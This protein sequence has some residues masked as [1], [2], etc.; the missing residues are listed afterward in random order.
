[1]RGLCRG[2]FATA[3]YATVQV[4]SP[5]TTRAAVSR[6]VPQQNSDALFLLPAPV[7]FQT[8]N[9]WSGLVWPGI[10]EIP[11]CWTLSRPGWKKGFS[12]LQHYLPGDW[13]V[14]GK[15]YPAQSPETL[16][17]VFPVA[18]KESRCHIFL[19]LPWVRQGERWRM[20]GALP[21]LKQGRTE[22]P[23]PRPGSRGA[24]SFIK[25]RLVDGDSN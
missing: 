20:E 7:K 1:M 2:M 4:F 22:C 16:R 3:C 19:G 13:R 5:W 10:G 15:F 6:Q 11:V 14:Q 17:M 23:S 9:G 21:R 12:G 24:P 18:V 25:A 8:G